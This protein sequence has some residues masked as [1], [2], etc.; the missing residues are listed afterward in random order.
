MKLN[1]NLSAQVLQEKCMLF[2]PCVE[3]IWHSFSFEGL[4]KIM[5][6][7][8]R[9][10]IKAQFRPLLG[11]N[12]STY[13][14]HLTKPIIKYKVEICVRVPWGKIYE[15]KVQSQIYDLYNS[16]YFTL[17]MRE[18][19]SK[20]CESCQNQTLCVFGVEEWLSVRVGFWF[21]IIMSI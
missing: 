9:T 11:R 5:A 13:F 15:V 10:F 3:R 2:W 20:K 16:V 1:T 19:I 6:K 8:T 12:S 7:G 17:L 4:W 18:K 14:V 21:G